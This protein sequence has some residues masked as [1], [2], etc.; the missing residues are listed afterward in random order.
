MNEYTALASLLPVAVDL[1][2]SAIN[3]FIDYGDF[4]SNTV[5]EYIQIRK[6]ELEFYRELN[7]P[8][9]SS[10]KWVEAVLRLLRP[11]VVLV[12]LLLWC[13]MTTKGTDNETL[14]DFTSSIMFYLFGDRTLFYTKRKLQS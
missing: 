14:N 2:K 10:Y 13:Y 5:E 4:K 3:R 11:V 9:R 8:G 1:G 6:L 7:K 12:V